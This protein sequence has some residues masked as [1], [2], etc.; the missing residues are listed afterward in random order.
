[1]ISVA[2][3]S[4]TQQA[5]TSAANIERPFR[6]LVKGRLFVIDAAIISK[7]S[8]IFARMIDVQENGSDDVQPIREIVD[9]SDE[10]IGAF[11]S[12]CNDFNLVNGEHF[13]CLFR[14]SELNDKG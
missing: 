13:S 2:K 4:C 10:D 3:D 14:I 1:M 9:E 7:L 8:P 6:L 12:C 5:Q 11:L